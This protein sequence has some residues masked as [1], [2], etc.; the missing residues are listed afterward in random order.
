MNDGKRMQDAKGAVKAERVMITTIAFFC[1][2]EWV[3]GSSRLAIKQKRS[4]HEIVEVHLSSD[5]I[6]DMVFSLA[7]FFSF[8]MRKEVFDCSVIQENKSKRKALIKIVVEFLR[9]LGISGILNLPLSSAIRYIL[10]V[11]EH[12]PYDN[13]RKSPYHS[14]GHA[15][16]PQKP[17]GRG[18]CAGK[19]CLAPWY[20]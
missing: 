12:A 17:L 6:S 10:D 7:I 19:K 9:S 5:F 4:N 20:G 3:R 18:N 11:M 15:R 1:H 2:L 16:A 13:H 8:E 14:E